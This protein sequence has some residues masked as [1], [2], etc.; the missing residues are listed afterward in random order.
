VSPHLSYL[1]TTYNLRLHLR[2]SFIIADQAIS[3]ATCPQNDFVCKFV[4]LLG[5]QRSAAATAT[6]VLASTDIAVVI[7]IIILIVGPRHVVSWL[8]RG[9][10][11][12]PNVAQHTVAKQLKLCAV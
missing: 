11:S 2:N 7:I 3:L 4:T 10:W 12:N 1:R 8:T 9:R 6:K 5:S